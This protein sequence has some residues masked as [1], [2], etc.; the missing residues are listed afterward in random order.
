MGNIAYPLDNYALD[1]HQSYGR[2][3]SQDKDHLRYHLLDSSVLL[4]FD[5]GDLE[6]SASREALQ[7]TDFT[8]K[9]IIEK[10]DEVLKDI[11]SKVGQRFDNCNTLWEAKCFWQETFAYGG[12]GHS[13]S[14]IV[15][16]SGVIW[17]GQKIGDGTFNFAKSDIKL[18]CIVKIILLIHVNIKY[19]NL[20]L[21]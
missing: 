5:I 6:I 1:I 17:K 16:K 20:S 8:K 3:N 18:K 15:S 10:L 9:N 12:V 19:R 14:N 13:L 4:K 21:K 2:N 7:Y 11:P